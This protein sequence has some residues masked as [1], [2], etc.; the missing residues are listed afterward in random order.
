MNKIIPNQYVAIFNIIQSENQGEKLPLFTQ[1]L[2]VQRTEDAQK[3]WIP[4]Q[5]NI[6]NKKNKKG[7]VILQSQVQT[8]I[9]PHHSIFLIN[10]FQYH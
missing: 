7:T 4:M 10:G 8:P 9:R 1:I 3:C 5:A 2:L 6:K